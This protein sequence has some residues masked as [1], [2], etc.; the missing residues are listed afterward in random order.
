MQHFSFLFFAL[1]FAGSTFAQSPVV[2]NNTSNSSIENHVLLTEESRYFE[3]DLSQLYSLTENA[4][5][6]FTSAGRN[7]QT[8]INLP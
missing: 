2:W 4:P 1:I 6:E 3:L 8:I 7:S 5:M